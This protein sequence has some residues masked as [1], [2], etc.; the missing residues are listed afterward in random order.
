MGLRVTFVDDIKGRGSKIDGQISGADIVIAKNATDPVLK[1]FGHEVS[2]WLEWVAPEEYQ[3]LRQFVEQQGQMNVTMRLFQYRM[4]GVPLDYDGVLRGFVSDEVGKMIGNPTV[5]DE[6][7]ARNKQNR[8]M[9]AERWA[10]IALGCNHTRF[11][12]QYN[13]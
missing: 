13:I 11:H 3:T 1:V 5:L 8:S 9:A 4:A 2:H 7:I 12:R 10:P 6:F